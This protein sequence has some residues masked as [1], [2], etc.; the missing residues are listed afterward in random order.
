[1]IGASMD[2]CQLRPHQTRGVHACAVL[3]ELHGVAVC[4]MTSRLT[5]RLQICRCTQM[6]YDTI[7]KI[8]QDLPTRRCKMPVKGRHVYLHRKTWLP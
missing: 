8:F 1:M 5:S 6:N 2:T 4:H 3:L 7:I